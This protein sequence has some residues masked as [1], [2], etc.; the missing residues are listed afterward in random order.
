MGRHPSC[1]E[2]VPTVRG[3]GEVEPDVR[4][5]HGVRERSGGDDVDAEPSQRRNAR[6][7]DSSGGFGDGATLGA[8]NGLTDRVVV[9]VVEEDDVCAGGERLV[10][11]LERVDLA[12]DPRGVGGP[13][14]GAAYRGADAAAR[15]DVVVFDED[16]GPEV[17]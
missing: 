1:F 17:V 2:L 10:E 12:L 3:S 16:S 7:G 5:L 14:A 9:H 13:R 8:S 11:L 15:G 6:E 4:A